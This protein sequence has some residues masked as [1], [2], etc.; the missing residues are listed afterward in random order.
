MSAQD[1]ANTRPLPVALQHRQLILD[2]VSKGEILREIASDLGVTKQSLHRYLKD[3]PEYQEAKR[4]Q[5]A[6]M[7]EEAKVETWAAREP[8]DI[9]RA[10]EIARFAFR[11]AESVDPQTW[12]QKRELTVTVADFGERLRRAK[13]RVIEHDAPQQIEQKLPN[14][15]AN[16]SE[17]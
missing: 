8:A 4:E 1:L 6:A 5:A 12:G 13:E 10:R 11:Y 17:S 14:K 15:E 9:A 7:I 16:V 3:D 2:R